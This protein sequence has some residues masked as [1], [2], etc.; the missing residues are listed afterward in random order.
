MIVTGHEKE[1]CMVC[2]MENPPIDEKCECGG[3]GFIYGDNF[4]FLVNK[5]LC[6]C[7]NDVFNMVFSID[8]HPVYTKNYQC[9]ECGNLIGTQVYR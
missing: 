3:R 5:V 4:E 6:H 7:G 9:S 1:Y 8:V 2:G